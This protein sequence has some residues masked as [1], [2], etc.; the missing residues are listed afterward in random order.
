MKKRIICV[1]FAVFI[2]ISLA[3]IPASADEQYICRLDDLAN[4]KTQLT[5]QEKDALNGTIYDLSQKCKCNVIFVTVDDLSDTSFKHNGTTQDYADVYYEKECGINTDGVLVLLTFSNENGKREMYISTSGKCIK[6]LSDSERE[7]IF[8]DVI[9]N[10]NPDT[11][12]YAD[13]LSAIA[14]GLKEAIPPHVGF[15]N[16]LIAFGIGLIIAIIVSLMLRG[17]LKTVKMQHGA[18]NYV[19]PGSM[20]VNASR[21]TYLYSTV[22]RTARPKESSGGTHTSSGGGSHGGGGR[23]F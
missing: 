18:A 7:A 16:L 20:M 4:D 15:K 1:L 9:D 13:Y 19:H 5:P 14:K 2:V 22:S 3:I 10:H 11:H 8:D 17:Q 23:T 6:R 12:G 21:D